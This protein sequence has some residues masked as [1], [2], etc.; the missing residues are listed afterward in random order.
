MLREIDLYFSEKDEPLRACLEAL[1][2][3]ILHHAP[4][5]TEVWQYKMPFYRF[6]GKRFCYL[7]MDKRTGQPYIGFVDGKRLDHPEL[8]MEKRSRMKIF[9]IDATTD[10]PV[11]TIRELLNAAIGLLGQS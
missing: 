11:E 6:A 9:R 8:L 3:L 5:I 10:L 1:R 4:Q 7:W 2:Y